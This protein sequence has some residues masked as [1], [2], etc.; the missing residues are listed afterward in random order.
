MDTATHGL[1]VDADMLAAVAPQNQA[2][3]VEGS[4]LG[5]EV[6]QQAAEPVKTPYH[7]RIASREGWAEAIVFDH[8]LG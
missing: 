7:Q 8:P 6:F 4:N 3:L 5:D 2:T 1:P